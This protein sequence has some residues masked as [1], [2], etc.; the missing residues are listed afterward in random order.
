VPIYEFMHP[1]TGEIFEEMRKMKDRDKPF[2]AP[3]GVL[4]DRLMVPTSFSGWKAD[5]EV[6]EADRDFVKKGKPK[7]VKFKDGHR[8][9]YDPTKH[10]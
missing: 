2:K 3:D 5:K 4:C 8:E 1:E 10:C 6:F 7:Y 9:R